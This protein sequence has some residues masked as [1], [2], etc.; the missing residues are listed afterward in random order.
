MIVFVVQERRNLQG[1]RFDD[2]TCRFNGSE[3]AVQAAYGAAA[4]IAAKLVAL[5]ADDQPY[6]GR[7]R[8]GTWLFGGDS[9]HRLAGV[10]AAA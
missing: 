10:K 7:D 5:G 3:F 9:L 2:V 6:E 8:S 1:V 4:V